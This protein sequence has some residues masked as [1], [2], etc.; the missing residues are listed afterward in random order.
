MRDSHQEAFAPVVLL[1]PFKDFD[2]ALFMVNDS[3]FGLQASV[4][5]NDINRAF[6]A[7]E[8]LEVGGVIINDYPTFRIDPMPYGGTKDS[9]L[10]REGIRYTIG[11]MT[12]S[13][14]L[15]IQGKP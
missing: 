3:L 9:G 14:L 5:T 7:Y 15:V 10:G 1:S 12:E 4:F 2:D 8:E 11:E 13:K 6:K